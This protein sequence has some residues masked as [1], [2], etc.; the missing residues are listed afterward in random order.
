MKINYYSSLGQDMR[1]FIFFSGQKIQA[2]CAR[3]RERANFPKSG[4]RNDDHFRDALFGETRL[5]PLVID[6]LFVQLGGLLVMLTHF[7]IIRR[8][9]ERKGKQVSEMLLNMSQPLNG[10]RLSLNRSVMNSKSQIG[11]MAR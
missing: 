2:G 5:N 1:F 11:G 10:I 3:R 7:V 6:V 9:I 8:R 4:P